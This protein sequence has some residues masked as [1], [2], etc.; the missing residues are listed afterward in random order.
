MALSTRLVVLSGIFLAGCAVKFDPVEH[1]RIVDIHFNI[2]QAI[3]T[4][5]C[6]YPV[7]MAETARTI[8]RDA[9]WLALYVQHV[10]NNQSLQTMSTEFAKGSQDLAARYEPSKPPPSKIFCELRLKNLNTQIEVI[11][12]TNARRPR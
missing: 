9:D 5:Q 12:R 4:N 3:S 2:Q 10:P 11:Q 8:A 1:A 7:S 6:S